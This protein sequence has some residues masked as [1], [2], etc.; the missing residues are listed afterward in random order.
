MSSNSTKYPETARARGRLQGVSAFVAACFGQMASLCGSHLIS[1]VLGIW[2]YQQTRS[3]TSFALIAFFAIVPEIVLSPLAGAIADLWDRRL[4]MIVGNFGAALSTLSLVAMAL[5]NQLALWPIYLVVAASS[6]F[7]AV[8]YPALSASIPFWIKEGNLSR[9]NAIVEVGNSIAMVIAPALAPVLLGAMGL[10]GI[11]SAAAAT[12]VLAITALAVSH[13]P[14]PLHSPG[15]RVDFFSLLRDALEGW[16]YVQRRREL[17][18]LL[19]LFAVTNFAVGT[20]QVLLPPFVLSFSSAT[21]LGI[22]MSSAGSGAIAGGLL[23][24]TLGEIRHKIRL[25]L[26]LVLGQGMVLFLGVLRP[27]IPLVAAAAFLFSFGVPIIFASSQTIWQTEVE[28]EMQGRAFAIRKLVAWSSLP[29]AYL[30]AGP[31]ADR[32]F[33][34]LMMPTGALAPSIGALIGTGTGRG[35]ALLFIILGLLIASA[36]CVGFRYRPFWQLEEHLLGDPGRQSDNK[37]SSAVFV[38]SCK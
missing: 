27:D 35:I 4:V 20:V 19:V 37:N 26:L 5:T 6:A 28:Q 12:F 2:I 22:V 38:T 33:G 7:Q 8:Q 34:P 17:F 3:S 23:L 29:L 10:K 1:F 18:A 25:I 32:V 16:N 13:F 14:C 11:F 24:S 15:H 9:A 36:V 31:L 21:G 30:L